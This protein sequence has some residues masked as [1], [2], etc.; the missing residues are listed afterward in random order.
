M[1]ERLS[2]AVRR[3][4][5]KARSAT[6]LDKLSRQLGRPSVT[7]DLFSLEETDR[8]LDSYGIGRARA[9]A[10]CGASGAFC[11]KAA[12]PR[13]II[14]LVPE[15]MLMPDKP[16]MVFPTDREVCGAARTTIHEVLARLDALWIPENGDD[17]LAAT[18]DGSVGV[19]CAYDEGFGDQS[20]RIIAWFE[21]Q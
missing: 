13:E 18:A 4:R 19:F 1:S 16:A 10:E 3:N 8:A 20:C 6:Y 11:A 17:V 5:G 21:S 9:E 2:L 12:S 15:L 14:S 7:I